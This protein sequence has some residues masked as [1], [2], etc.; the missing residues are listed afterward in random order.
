M[1]VANTNGGLKGEPEVSSLSTDKT[2]KNCD[3]AQVLKRSICLEQ[4]TQAW[5]DN[6]EKYQPTVSGLL[7]WTCWELSHGSHLGL[8][9]LVCCHPGIY[10]E[11][12]EPI[13]ETDPAFTVQVFFPVGSLP[14]L[15]CFILS[16]SDP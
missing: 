12:K 11:W 14:L 6:C 4:N 9:R 8:A 7:H 13:E 1:G 10:K 15:V 16:D 3:F 2:G 5:C